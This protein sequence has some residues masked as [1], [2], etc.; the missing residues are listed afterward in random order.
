MAE[1]YRTAGRYD[2]LFQVFKRLQDDQI[3]GGSLNKIA[4]A[5]TTQPL[6]KAWERDEASTTLARTI[7]TLLKI[8]LKYLD[9][10]TQNI[11]LGE[12]WS[13]EEQGA[14]LEQQLLYLC[15]QTK[16]STSLSR[17]QLATFTTLLSIYDKKVYPIRRLRVLI[18]LMSIRSDIHESLQAE[19][20]KELRMDILKSH[21]VLRSDDASLQTYWLHYQALAIS[22]VELRQDAP[23]LELLTNSIS[24]W[25]SILKDCADLNA[26]EREVDDVAGLIR[27]L[28]VIATFLQVQGL[29]RLRI[30]VLQVVNG[31]SEHMDSASGDD[32]I[33]ISFVTLGSQWLHLG[34]SGRAG[35]ALDKAHI[36]SDRNGTSGIPILQ[37]HVA[38]A[39]YLLAIGN[40]E[41]AE[42]YLHRA[43]A[44]YSCDSAAK[45]GS[46]PTTPEE[47]ASKTRLLATAYLVHS[48]L[49]LTRGATHVALNHAKQ[50]VRLLR[51]AWARV[52]EHI[53]RRDAA[54]DE[55]TLQSDVDRLAT[56][57]SKL[58]MS[59]VSISETAASLPPSSQSSFWT[60][61]IPLFRSLNHL[62]EVYAHHGMFQ[63]TIYYAEQGYNMVKGFNS[64]AHQAMASTLMGNI[65]LR[66][67][68]LDKGSEMLLAAKEFSL[69]L[70]KSRDTALLAHYMGNMYGTLGDRD[71]ELASYQVAENTV[72]LLL[73]DPPPTATQTGTDLEKGMEELSL[74]SSKGPAKRKAPDRSKPDVK[75]KKT[76]SRSK[77]PIPV[78]QPPI[79]EEC[80][81]LRSLKS[82]IL[83]SKV[84]VLNVMKQFKE[85][86]KLLE[87][88]TSSMKTQVEVVDHRL[89]IAK[90]LLLESLGYMTA[91]PV[92]SV[93]Q[94]ST[95]SFP[96]VAVPS[97]G[98]NIGDKLSVVKTTPPKRAPAGRSG[99]AQIRP[100]SAASTTCFEKLC[101]A[102]EYLMEAHSIAI[103]SSPMDL[104]HK[105]ASLL[106]SVSILLSASGYS[107]G[108]AMASPAFASA[109]IEMARNLAL[110]RERKTILLD[111]SPDSRPEDSSWP[112]VGPT[113]EIRSS[114]I[115]SQDLSRFQKDY[116]D[117]IPSSWTAVSISLSESQNELV[118]TRLQAG[119]GPFVL[120]LP[121]GRHNSMDADEEVFGFEQGRSELSEIIKL[122]NESA[123][124]SRDTN[125]KEAKI[126]WWEEREE[127][128]ARLK[129]L[130]ENIEKVWLGG[131][132]GIFSQHALR[133]DLLARFQK[134][135]Q[136]I[137]NKHL[138]SRQKTK[139]RN[140]SPCVTLDPRILD[141]FIGLGDASV[142]DADFS[143]PLTDLLYFVIDV[144]QFQGELNAYAEIDFDSI[145]VET[146]DALRYYHEAVHASSGVDDRRHTV[147]ILD[148]ALHAFPWESIP[149]MIGQAVSRLPSLGCLRE[150]IL[151][152]QDEERGDSREGQYVDRNS[153]AYVLNPSGDLKNTQATFRKSLQALKEWDGTIEREPS[154]ARIQINLASK[155]IFLYFGHGS[156]AQYIRAKEI[157]KLE[158]CSVAFLMGC[159]SGTL[160]EVGEF[161]PYGPAM[162]YMHAGCPALV[163]TLWD[164]TDKDIDRFAKTTFENWDLFEKEDNKSEKK[165]KG[166]KK[167]QASVK[168]RQSL[169]EAVS[170]GREACHLRYL[171]AAAVCVY[172][173]PVYLR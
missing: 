7:H 27:H 118:V 146:Q 95:I 51:R 37:L 55:A 72:D 81:P 173:V 63:E 77:S 18:E 89:T 126:A 155:D 171:N 149:C 159:S 91:D 79:S 123:H 93:L 165:G 82:T 142:E 119:Q 120:R 117:I 53:R 33:V 143:E 129:D 68:S 39:E 133:P 76:S 136:N 112:T 66:S 47:K 54:S 144:L 168:Q 67:G 148:K 52:E 71:A 28:Q 106:N 163:A 161:E 78:V 49:A 100:K 147:L 88:V 140:A 19:V 56:S 59:T 69:P 102:Q 125:S 141:L 127:L 101:Q 107:K 137:L 85:A 170:K 156:G 167:G 25:M 164:V 4:A 41:K 151:L 108:K 30:T 10:T 109:G 157:R 98:E 22:T 42:E 73:S 105:L 131:F 138:P 83:R 24:K 31:L 16:T 135:F 110:R 65:Y 113:E 13:V 58:K 94:D 1:M 62:S 158:R 90:Q 34:Y 17:L 162:N 44:I 14:F 92:Y 122:A 38:Y 60:L 2:E 154:E 3:S 152:Q 45:S 86:Q 96:S 21:N 111:S 124:S 150:R 116:I 12:T 57:V 9:P 139:K 169:I 5:L 50:S 15:N 61:I 172:G 114:L 130:L 104:I 132:T 87:G 8:Q 40:I 26:L 48:K 6:R 166:R 75:G 153:G 70:E 115:L 36:H 64:E 121:L 84:Q 134:S 46:S 103:V 32:N 29:E 74:S 160:S 97:R 43:Q 99:R 11:K 35:L 80:S 23:S 20:G 128:D 145:V